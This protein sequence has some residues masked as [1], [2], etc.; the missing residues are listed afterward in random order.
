[1]THRRRANERLMGPSVAR[2]VHWLMT[3]LPPTLR[4]L[5]ARLHGRNPSDSCRNYPRA[6]T[7]P[8]CQDE[9]F[10]TRLN[11]LAPRQLGPA[12]AV[13]PN[14]HSLGDKQL[15]GRHRLADDDA[16]RRSGWN[17]LGQFESPAL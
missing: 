11:G 16:H 5:P 10:A 13:I 17:D 2:R 7:H 3:A 12:A 9:T 14:A 1:M 15:F 4:V 6:A 8:P